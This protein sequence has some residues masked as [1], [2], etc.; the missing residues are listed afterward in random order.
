[1][2]AAGPTFQQQLVRPRG[3]HGGDDLCRLDNAAA[4]VAYLGQTWSDR[5]CLS[6]YCDYRSADGY[7]RKYRFVFVDGEVYPYHLAISPD[8]MVHYWRTEM[9]TNSWMQREEEA[10]LADY[11]SL[12]GSI[13]VEAL[14]NCAGRLGLDYAG[15]DCALTPDGQVLLFEANAS[16]RVQLTDSDQHFGYKQRYL[17]RIFEAIGDMVLRRLSPA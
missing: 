7:Y 3:S 6:D 16:M 15:I 17:P 13:G 11:H 12:F 5:F 1:M 4:L 14:A 9:A 8:W 10:F 2:A